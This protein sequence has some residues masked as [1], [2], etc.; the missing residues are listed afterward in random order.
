MILWGLM[1]RN[2]YLEEKVD[3]RKN[4]H[5]K[6]TQTIRTIRQSDRWQSRNMCGPDQCYQKK[7]M[8]LLRVRSPFFL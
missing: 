4:Q 8:R 3:K 1:E 2:R 6:Q 7:Y 5:E